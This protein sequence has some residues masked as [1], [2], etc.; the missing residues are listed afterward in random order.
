MKAKIHDAECA[1]EPCGCPVAG[2][3]KHCS[4]WCKNAGD[5]TDCGC[6]H[7]DCRAEA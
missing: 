1:H 3:G 2:S 4:Y 7:A 5:S 6:G